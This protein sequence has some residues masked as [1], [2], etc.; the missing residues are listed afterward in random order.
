MTAD[1]DAFKAAQ[2]IPGLT[3]EEEQYLVTV[4]RG[5]G[6]YGLGWGNP[7][8]KTIADSA[9]FGLTGK[10][11]AGSNNWGAVQ[12]SGNGGSFPHVDFHSDGTPYK[13]TF[14]VYKTNADG[15]TDMARILLKPNVRLALSMGDLHGAVLAQHDNGYFE[16]NPEQYFKAVVRNYRALL[17]NLAWPNL[18]MAPEK[19]SPSAPEVADSPLPLSSGF[20]A[21]EWGPPSSGVLSESDLLA[22]A[23]NYLQGTPNHESQEQE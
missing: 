2:Q 13:G 15:A 1:Q 7:S 6:F 23:E 8:A 22:H 11:G 17:Q 21:S 12:G 14:R 3:P 19:L 16:L 10:E 20:L 5:E 9:A 4:A 18:L